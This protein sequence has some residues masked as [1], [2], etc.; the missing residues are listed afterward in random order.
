M[1]YFM[2]SMK[3]KLCQS[4]PEVEAQDEGECHLATHDAQYF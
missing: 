1:K 2:Y 4:E 3:C